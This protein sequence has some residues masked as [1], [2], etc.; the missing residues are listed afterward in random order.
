MTA[1]E[2]K[3]EISDT[4]SGIILHSGSDS[5][6]SPVKDL[7]THTRALKLKHQS[8]EERLELCLLEL[9][10][11]CIREA[12]LTGQLPSDYPLMPDEKPPQ[13]RRRIGASF[14]LDEG[15]IYLEN[16]DSELQ[17]LETELALQRQIYEAARRLSLEGNLSKPQ[18]KSRVQQCKREEKKV[19]DLQEAVFQHRIK[20]ECSSPCVSNSTCKRNDLNMS[21]DSSLS[22]V[23]ALDDDMDSLGPIS[24]PVSITDPPSK[25][26]ESSILEYERSPIQNS[27]WKE[28]S[29]DQPYQKN[30]KPLS[31]GGSGS[32]SPAGTRVSAD[33]NR[34]P[35][36]QFIKNSAL[37]HQHSTSAPSTPEL[38]VRRQ[39]SQSFRLPKSKP[40]TDKERLGLENLKG[41]SRLPLRRCA[42]DF[43]VLSPESSP[44]RP[45]QSSSEDS[46]SEHSSSS[47]LSSPG[48]EG[49]TEIPKL[50]PPP[51]GFHFGAPKKVLPCDLPKNNSNQ[52]Q[53]RACTPLS[54]QDLGKRFV[55]SPPVT[56]SIPQQR[57]WQEQVSTPKLP[58]PYTS[59]VRTPS[60]KEYPN[61]AIRAMPREVVSEE[62]K[63][64][65]QRSQNPNLVEQQSPMGVKSP[66]SPHMPPFHQG[67]GNLVLQRA[68]DGTPVQ[69]F[70]AE[71]AEIV[72]QV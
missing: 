35:L 53:L 18:K 54:P 56:R 47:Y 59:V 26:L 11:L 19:K 49:S 44:M 48:R 68:A 4:D 41:P 38:H 40:A 32:S 5:P 12:E 20:S 71:D 34:I 1:I 15:L 25:N 67:S 23:V 60:L 42:A 70:V 21:D 2:S 69:W 45:Y 55:S 51:Y 63:S 30:L 33:T 36:S 14:K 9:R 7:T 31:V 43:I 72:S 3:E 29:L 64:W 50:C 65:H 17:E 46:S 27:P 10:K 8:L 16:E 37:R 66:T 13:V 28:S 57:P 24:T 22:D 39:Y 52:P 58:P 62:L 61:H 6:T